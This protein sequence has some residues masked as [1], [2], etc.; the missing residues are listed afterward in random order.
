M[1]PK[2]WF[3]E[4]DADAAMWLRALVTDGFLPSGGVETRSIVDL[5]PEDVPRGADAHFFAGIGG[6]PL[7]LEMSEWPAHVPVWTGSCPCQPF[8]SAGKNDGTDDERHLW[9]AWLR[10]IR[11]HRPLVAVGEQVA[12]PSAH[13]WMRGVQDD[14]E[15]AGYAVG[16]AVLPAAGVAAPHNRAR[17]YWGAVLVDHA[18]GAGRE[19]R[20]A[21]GHADGAVQKPLPGP[22]RDHR[23]LYCPFDGKE[24]RIPLDAA[25][26]VVA[27]GLPSRMAELAAKGFGN[28][29]V[30]LVASVFLDAFGQAAG[31]IR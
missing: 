6:W 3:N 7:A 30:P 8:S 12:S 22:W 14:L 17:I 29:I 19:L 20:V 4:L 25:I 5:K 28:A 27:H 18:V 26:P 23:R 15:S 9:P 1:R 24:R 11:E 13:D 10:L 2:A 16:Y 31:V 21:A